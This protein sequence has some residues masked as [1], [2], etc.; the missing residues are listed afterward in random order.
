[1]CTKFCRNTETQS[2]ALTSWSVT[3][4]YIYNNNIRWKGL[5]GCHSYLTVCTVVME[6]AQLSSH[7][8][9]MIILFITFMSSHW[10][11]PWN[12]FTF[13]K[14]LFI[15]KWQRRR[16]DAVREMELV[17][18]LEGLIHIHTSHLKPCCFHDDELR[19]QWASCWR[20]KAKEHLIHSFG[21][22]NSSERASQELDRPHCHNHILFTV[23]LTKQRKNWSIKKIISRLFN[24]KNN[25]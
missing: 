16:R 9:N 17:Q 2:W 3:L 14:R 18:T 4:F 7:D 15:L 25:C 10:W 24:N 12:V 1:M 19:S 6:M 11:R 21:S 8:L 20:Q 13:F 23:S 22:L 5:T